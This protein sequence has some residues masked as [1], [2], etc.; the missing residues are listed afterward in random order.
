MFLS[1][2]LL[3][4]FRLYDDFQLPR[5]GVAVIDV[6]GASGAIIALTTQTCKTVSTVHTCS[7]ILTGTTV[8][9][10]LLCCKYITFSLKNSPIMLKHIQ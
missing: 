8:T 10:V 6:I 9:A 5:K 7:S 4:I 1:N 3:T 2:A